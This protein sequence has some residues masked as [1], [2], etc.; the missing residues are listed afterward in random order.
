MDVLNCYGDGFV[1]IAFGSIKSEEVLLMEFSS[2]VL[3][4]ISDILS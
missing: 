4:E 2:A 1:M 3:S